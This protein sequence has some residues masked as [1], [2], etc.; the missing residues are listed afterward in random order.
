MPPRTRAGDFS[1]KKPYKLKCW[2]VDTPSGPANFFTCARPGREEDQDRRVSDEL[3]HRWVL[4]LPGPNAAV[5]SLLGRKSNAKGKSE[6]SYYSFCG[7]FDALL[8]RKNRLS[9]QEWLDHHHKDLNI[10][11]HEHPTFDYRDTIPL[12]T[13]EAVKS[14]ILRLI[15]MDHRVIVVDSGGVGRTGLVCC[16]MG[17]KEDSSSQT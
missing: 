14:E 17:A 16:Y 6:F 4:G 3:V 5:V 13:L 2:V 10:L 7:G 8:E 9:F 12:T 1:P 15:S 11:V